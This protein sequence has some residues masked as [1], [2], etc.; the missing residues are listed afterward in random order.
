MI[1][2]HRAIAEHPFILD[3]RERVETS[4]RYREALYAIVATPADAATIARAALGLEPEPARETLPVDYASETA[5]DASALVVEAA[6]EPQE[7]TP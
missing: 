5:P 1:D 2:L 6:T 7:T 4:D 3:L